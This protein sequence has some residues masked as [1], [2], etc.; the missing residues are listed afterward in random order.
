M[1]YGDVRRNYPETKG[2]KENVNGGRRGCRYDS[3]ME[4]ELVN[5]FNGLNI[6]ADK[7]S[8]KLR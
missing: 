2:M 8:V 7:I 5:F 4:D 1:Q 6:L 3:E